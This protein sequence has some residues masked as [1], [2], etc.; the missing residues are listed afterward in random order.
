MR[1][2]YKPHGVAK[3]ACVA[4]DC[5]NCSNLD[6]RRPAAQRLVMQMLVCHTATATYQICVVT[7]PSVQCC[8]LACTFCKLIGNM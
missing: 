2:I 7:L 8:E 3:F 4:S 5:D 1:L 6:T